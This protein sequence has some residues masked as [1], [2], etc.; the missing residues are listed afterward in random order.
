[1][2]AVVFPPVPAFYHRPKTLDDVINQTVTRILDQFDI[3]VKL[4]HRWDDEGMS[5]HPGCGQAQTDA[6]QRGQRAPGSEEAALSLVGS[7]DSCH[8]AGSKKPLPRPKQRKK[9]HLELCL[10]TESVSSHSS[11]GLDRY[12]FVHNALP[13]ARSRR[14]RCQHDVSRQDSSRRRS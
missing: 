7:P 2:G 11:T 1:M 4:F 8:A 14:D 10:D 12:R 9:E 13:G 5:R 6:D 3:D